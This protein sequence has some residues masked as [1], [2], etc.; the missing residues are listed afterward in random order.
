MTSFH[1]LLWKYALSQITTSFI[2]LLNLLWIIKFKTIFFDISVAVYIDFSRWSVCDLPGVYIAWLFTT[3]SVSLYRVP[4]FVYLAFLWY[5]LLWSKHIILTCNN[6]L[7]SLGYWLFTLHLGPY[8]TKLLT[9]KTPFVQL[10]NMVAWYETPVAEKLSYQEIV[11]CSEDSCGLCTKRAKKS[12]WFVQFFSLQHS[13]NL[14]EIL[15]NFSTKSDNAL[16]I[17]AFFTHTCKF[18]YSFFLHYRKPWSVR[19]LTLQW[20]LKPA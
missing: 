13:E 19:S 20:F 2:F 17:S 8:Q 11:F 10:S 14:S 1:T 6:A 5:S 18:K 15:I 3:N 16:N 4:E 7:K 9:Y 12:A